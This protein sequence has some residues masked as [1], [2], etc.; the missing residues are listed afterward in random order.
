[1]WKLHVFGNTFGLTREQAHDAS[2]QV[3]EW[4]QNARVEHN[5]HYPQT[6]LTN[7]ETIHPVINPI[8]QM[9]PSLCNDSG[10]CCYQ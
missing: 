6:G 4:D 9:K 1:L 8:P 7:H 10:I 2:L 3:H 5:G